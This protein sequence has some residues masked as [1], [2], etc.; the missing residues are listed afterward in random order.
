MGERKNE[1]EMSGL[2]LWIEDGM[3]YIQR[4]DGHTVMLDPKHAQRLG[5]DL[6]AIAQHGEPVSVDFAKYGTLS[7]EKGN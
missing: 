6:I 2:K 7:K 4:K 3:L 1:I 5:N